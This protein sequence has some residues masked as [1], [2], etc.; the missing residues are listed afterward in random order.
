MSGNNSAKR[1]LIIVSYIE[2]CNA[3]FA[4]E[5]ASEAGSVVCA[6]AGQLIAKDYGITPD[7]VI[8]D[9]DST[10][11]VNI[12]NAD[13]NAS[14]YRIFDCEYRT[15]PAEKNTTDAEAA[16]EY[17][18]E[19]LGA[20]DIIIL[21]GIGGRLD[22]TL[23]AINTVR[24]F[25]LPGLRIRLMDMRNCAEFLFAPGKMTIEKNPSYKFFSIIP[26]DLY[27]EG[28]TVTG[29]KYP[30]QDAKIPRASALGVSNEISNALDEVTGRI[31]TAT[32]SIQKGDVIIVRSDD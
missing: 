14:N 24:E 27:S 10:D 1:C 4:R 3:E 18:V 15:Y 2:R 11:P 23:G 8:G 9:F 17:A 30:L 20:D 22:H 29:A 13:S 7:F 12:D 28:I 16:L 26:Y 32:I 21:G 19:E 5:L 6:D 25:C 31:D